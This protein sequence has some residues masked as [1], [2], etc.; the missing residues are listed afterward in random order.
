MS[1]L[2]GNPRGPLLEGL[3]V[4]SLSFKC[5]LFITPQLP[6]YPPNAKTTQSINN[7]CWSRLQRE[8][9][10]GFLVECVCVCVFVI[11]ITQRPRCSRC[12]WRCQA[13]ETV[14]V[15]AHQTVVTFRTTQARTN[16]I[17]LASSFCRQRS[18]SPLILHTQTQSRNDPDNVCTHDQR[19]IITYSAAK[20]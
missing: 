13:V 8:R 20:A 4:S 17:H 9:Q 18:R 1:N 15:A 19:T 10:R 3:R 5:R 12:W 2:F 16:N 11:W 6:G 14:L 7:S